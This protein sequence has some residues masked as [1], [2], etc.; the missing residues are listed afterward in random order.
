MTLARNSIKKK[1]Y[2]RL[3]QITVFGPSDVIGQRY[4]G[5]ETDEVTT[6]SE[7]RVWSTGDAEYLD[8]D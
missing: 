5:E 2:R 8:M 7:M 4:P 1:E 3:K 6:P